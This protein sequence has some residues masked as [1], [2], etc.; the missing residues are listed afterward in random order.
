[1]CRRKNKVNCI[2]FGLNIQGANPSARSKSFWKIPRIKE[3]LSTLNKQKIAVPFVALAETWLKN[4]ITDAEIKIPGYAI[5]RSDRAATPHGGVLL[6]VHQKIPIINFSCYD[7]NICQSVICFSKVNKCIIGVL[8]RPPTCSFQ[9]FSNLLD[10]L[11]KFILEFNSTNN[12]YVYIFGDFNL[13]KFNWSD[14]T[15]P[16]FRNNSPYQ[17]LFDFMGSHYLYQYVDKNTREN[18][19]L[20]LF[21]TSNPNFVHFV[22]CENIHISDHSLVKIFTNFFS[23]L[24]TDYCTHDSDN[25]SSDILDFSLLNLN[26][27]NFT[28]INN[29]LKVID[30]ERLINSS[31]VEEFPDKFRQ[32]VFTVLER[33]CSRLNYSSKIYTSVHKKERKIIAKKIRWQNK[34]LMSSNSL[35]AKEEIMVKISKLKK[36]RTQSFFKERS[37]Q[38]SLAISKIKTDSKYFFKYANRFKASLSSPSLLLDDSDNVI[39]DPLEIAN[40]LQSHFKTVFSVPNNKLNP[41]SNFVV[42]KISH[43]LPDFKCDIMDIISAINEI[44][45]HSSCPRSCIPAI[46]FKQCKYTL[47]KPLKLFYDKSFICGKVPDFYKSV[48]IIPLFK[49]GLKTNPANYRPIALTSHVI[50]ILER[51]IRFKLVNYFESNNFFNSNQHGFRKNH[52]CLSQLLSHFNNIQSSLL[53]SNT[54]DTIYVDYSKAFDKVDHFLLI[55]KLELYGITGKYLQWIQSFLTGRKQFVFIN[56]VSSDFVEVT[57]GVPQGSVLGPLF[58]IVFINDLPNHIKNSTVLTFADDTKIVF[59]INSENDSLLLQHDLNSLVAWSTE[60]NMSLNKNKFELLIH[61]QSINNANLALLET[62]PFFSVPNIYEAANDF[63]IFP[64]LSVKDLGITVTPDLDWDNH[65]NRICKS[66][67]R[68]SA[69]VLNVFY[70]RDNLVMLTLFN[71]L[72]R[73]RLEYCCQLWNPFKVKHIDAIEQ[74][75]RKFTRRIRNMKDHDYWTRLKLLNIMSLQRR[76]EK[77]I[78]LLVWKIKNCLVP[79]DINLEFKP[80]LRGSDFEAVV[81]PMVK[82]KGKFQTSYENSFIIK[83]AKIWNKLPVKLRDIK[84]YNLFKIKLEKYLSFFPDEPPVHGYYHKTNNS[85]LEYQTIKYESVFK[86]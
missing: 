29:E 40:K 77:L 64:S 72:V 62:L 73:S 34:K 14:N 5:F 25:H 48:Q 42:P 44:K 56:N 65:I 16:N 51:V 26:C 9:S 84:S 7:D 28:T 43:P 50:K 12:C 23:S 81:K 30:W 78:I 55:K 53:N 68:V 80:T 39:T 76:R 13:P 86:C 59:P 60:N 24:S 33:N 27:V 32:E 20:D 35:N 61:K 46:V 66:A 49:K 11:N 3:E 47:S 75:Q 41:L 85:I 63:Y 4:E 58:F 15:F 6:Y 57:S 69:W 21:L 31:T 2:C 71:S 18:N 17:L 54:V 45:T 83:S 37:T 1:M 38:E 22:K 19:I 82:T 70:S 67:N 52:S 8:Y 79:N 74:I 36:K 10:F